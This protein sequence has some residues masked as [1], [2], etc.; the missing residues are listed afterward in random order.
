MVLGVGELSYLF[1]AAES[2]AVCGSSRSAVGRSAFLGE[3][4][5]TDAQ[6]QLSVGDDHLSIRHALMVRAF[7]GCVMR[8]VLSASHAFKIHKAVVGPVSV[9][10]VDDISLRD[11]PVGLLP[12][13][14]MLKRIDVRSG[15]NLNVP[16]PIDTSPTFPAAASSAFLRDVMSWHEANRVTNILISFSSR[17]FGD[18]RL[19]AASA[20]AG[21]GRHIPVR[22]RFASPLDL[23]RRSRSR[24]V[25][26]DEARLSLRVPLVPWGQVET[27]SASTFSHARSLPNRA[28]ISQ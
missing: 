10:V 26:D 11:R 9:D 19:S 23:L 3:R 15:V 4:R 2:A 1:E 8:L 13:H 7:L 25:A 28:S 22:R 16:E 24:P 5:A 27:T 14:A 20:P 17:L 12:H 18:W 21:A 6:P